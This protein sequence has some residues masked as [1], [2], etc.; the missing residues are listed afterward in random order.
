MGDRAGQE[1]VHV[2]FSKSEIE[3]HLVA[4]TES[5]SSGSTLERKINHTLGEFVTLNSGNFRKLL[6]CLVN[7]V[8]GIGH[9]GIIC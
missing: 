1:F 5:L 8:L 9:G 7:S 3:S 6:D 2:P 4:S